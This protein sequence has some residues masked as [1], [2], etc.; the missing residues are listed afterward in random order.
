MGTLVPDTKQAHHTVYETTHL[1]CKKSFYM[2]TI[3][4]T[5]IQNAKHIFDKNNNTLQ[6]RVQKKNY[7]QLS[8]ITQ[9][10]ALQENMTFPYQGNTFQ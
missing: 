3:T 8:T 1:I 2:I 9:R 10:I 5:Y 4:T 7:G 6:A